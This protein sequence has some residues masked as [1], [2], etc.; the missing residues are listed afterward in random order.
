MEIQ[1]KH[2]SI[3][4][5][6]YSGS[7]EDLFVFDDEELISQFKQ[8]M[9]NGTPTCFL[10]SGYRGAG[11][12]SFIKRVSQDIKEKRSDGKQIVFINLNLAKYESYSL[13][14]RKII[15]QVYH[16]V[17]EIQNFKE[18]REKNAEIITSLELLYER[19]YREIVYSQNDSQKQESNLSTEVQVDVKK[20]TIALVL[21]LLT[22]LNLRFNIFEW[23]LDLRKNK[24]LDT[25]FFCAPLFWAAFELIKFNVKQTKNKTKYSEISR[26][27]LYDDEIAEF[28]L[29]KILVDLNKLR[30]L[31]VFI[32]DELD[33]ID[34]NEKVELLIAELKPLLLSGL[35]SFI[36]VSGQN[37]YYKFHTAHTHDDA[38]I[39]SIFSKTLH[40]PLLSTRT[41][42]DIFS[43]II[44]DP[45]NINDTN[46]IDYVKSKVLN[47]NRL[48]RRFLN[49]IRQDILWR[50][51]LAFIEIPEES[52]QVYKTD[53]LLLEQVEKIINEDLINT[54]YSDGIIDFFI[55][56]LHLWILKMKLKGS[57]FF[58]KE[59]IYNLVSDYKTS[60]PSWS[61]AR[62]NVIV[63]KLL[64][65]LTTSGLLEKKLE[66]SDDGEDIPYFRWTDRVT[67]KTETI[68]GV[69]DEF[70]SK[71]LRDF[72][73]LEKYIRTIYLEVFHDK[74][75]K[76]II[77]M[78]R[79]FVEIELLP[80]SW[81]EGNRL[82]VIIDLRN[83]IVHGQDVTIEDLD[84]VQ[85]YSFEINKFK[86]QFIEHYSFYM[87]KLHFNGYNLSVTRETQIV[88]TTNSRFRF[89]FIASSNLD[90]YPDA[91]FEVKI[92]NSANISIMKDNIYR[93]INS[94]KDYNIHS[95]KNNYLCFLIHAQGGNGKKTYSSFKS[96]LDNIVNN[97]FPSLATYISVYFHPDQGLD[98]ENNLQIY[99]DGILQKLGIN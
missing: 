56:Q 7:T 3:S 91:L 44:F 95:Q 45:A 72:I 12:T 54:D 79:K 18:I 8:E 1:I 52:K 59:D 50:D 66:R 93:T 57:S 22:G 81:I 2:N 30:I 6:P 46:V 28:Q 77:Q 19:T 9:L 74:N 31:P 70:Q 16:S 49:L 61:F 69:T 87:T 75:H 34:E 4:D 68:L 73:E 26:K 24:Y 92:I 78:L 94:F 65:D 76:S 58:C 11:K 41:F 17:T 55:T 99:L 80:R 37:L 35:A 96:L 60:H 85:N 43:N 62:L 10:I 27:T 5:S 23:L 71:F 97:E 98:T 42:F 39:A 20:M 40:I 15:R 25:L 89:D 48:P 84:H 38:L 14:L 86:A 21:L 47:S 82:N 83:K 29:N 67:I 36:L 53:A 33:K 51:N 13:L 63:V 88:P 90:Q 64:D 32:V